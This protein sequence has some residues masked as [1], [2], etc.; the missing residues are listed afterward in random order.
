MSQVDKDN[1][2]DVKEKIYKVN[3]IKKGVINKIII[4]SGKKVETDKE[5][6]FSSKEW[7]EIQEKNIPIEFTEQQI[8]IDDNITTVKIKTVR[9]SKTSTSGGLECRPQKR[10]TQNSKSVG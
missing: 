4:F 7:A 8:H 3:Y 5:K 2:L 9:F 6:Y 10:T 1:Y